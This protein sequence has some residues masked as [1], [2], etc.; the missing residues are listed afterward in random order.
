MMISSYAELFL[1]CA[2]I[3]LPIFYETS[4]KFRY[5]FKFFV[6]Y[7][8]VILN[9]FLLIPVFCLRPCNVRN[10]VLASKF[11]RVASPVISIKWEVRGAEHMS[12]DRAMVM[13]ANHQSS[14]DI[15]GMFDFWH[16]MDK[17]TVIA[18][19]ELFYAWPFGLAA[20][21]SGLIFI[22]RRHAER[23]QSAM[24]DSTKMLIEKR[25]KLW[26]FPE[27]TRRTTNEIHPFKK[28]AFHVAVRSQ[29]PILPIVYSS[30][31]TFLDDRQ[32]V[33]NPG[34]VIVTALPPIETTGLTVDDIPALIERTRAA[35]IETFKAST[36]EVENRFNLSG[37]AMQP[38]KEATVAETPRAL[39]S[40]VP[41]ARTPPSSA[42]SKPKATSIGD[43]PLEPSNCRDHLLLD[44]GPRKIG[45]LIGGA[46]DASP[47]KEPTAYRRKDVQRD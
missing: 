27:G 29:L 46:N 31:H 14:L 17:C 42:I 4:S 8:V 18:K 33:M 32:K 10:L 47:I 2:V 1:V 19:R 36:K 30:Y 15:L 20:W 26:V 41:P 40:V 21:L 5:F 22:D 23:A 25:T 24:N 34:H 11:C 13:V 37:H 45:S 9:S 3:L 39:A 7:A 38:G 12:A 43:H 35:M 28:G 44:A 16:L 6:Y